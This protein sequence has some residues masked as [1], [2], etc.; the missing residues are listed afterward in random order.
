M[1]H[2]STTSTFSSINHEFSPNFYVNAE[3]IYCD[4]AKGTNFALSL[5][6]AEAPPYGPIKEDTY[7]QMKIFFFCLVL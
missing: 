3:G 4:N 1:D 7:A 5:K 2:C 6:K